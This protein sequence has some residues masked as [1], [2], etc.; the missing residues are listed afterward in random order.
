MISLEFELILDIVKDFYDKANHD[1]LIGYHFR[2]IQDFESHIPRIASFWQL[3]LTGKLDAKEELPFN[4]LSV[5]KV[6]NINQ[7]EVFRWQKLF[8]E[9]LDNYEGQKKISSTQKKLWMEKIELFKTRIL[10]IV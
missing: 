10:Q 6:L 2:V 3:Q 1:I 8:E 4:L 5:H 7:G 9:T